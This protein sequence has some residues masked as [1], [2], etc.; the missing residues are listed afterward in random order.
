MHLAHT[1]EESWSLPHLHNW[2]IHTFSLA[3]HVGYIRGLVRQGG[4]RACGLSLM[5]K[6]FILLLISLVGVG[7][8]EYNKALK[9]KD[10]RVK[11]AAAEKYYAQEKFEKSVVLLEELLVLTRGTMESERVSYLHAMSWFGMKDFTL[12]GYYLENFAKT[13]TNSEHAEDC[14]F[15]SAYCNYKNSPEF[16]LDQGETQAAIDKLQL[17]LVKY[18]ETTLRDSSNHLMDRL[19]VKLEEKDWHAAAQ[20]M[21]TR[22]YQAASKSMTEFLRRWPNSKYR[23]QGYFSTLEADHQLAMNSVAKKKKERL[24]DAIRSYHNFADAF[25]EGDKRQAADRLFEE[26]TN[27]LNRLQTAAT[28]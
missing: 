14:Y 2:H 23:E 16:E 27:E 26:L 24:T 18:P 10:L 6:L 7:C 9:S 4:H 28:P 20:Y 17:F 25:S 3:S 19:Q 5:R 12:S 22:N 15:K 21:R 1:I 11:L 13:F 8:S